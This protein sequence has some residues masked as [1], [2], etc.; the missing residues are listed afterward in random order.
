[1]DQIPLNE[2]QPDIPAMG[3][4]QDG[5]GKVLVDAAAFG[6]KYQSKREVYWFVSH[7]CG[8][9][10]PD[11]ANVSI[12]HLGDLAAGRRKRIKEETVRQK[13]VPHFEKLTIETMLEY[14]KEKP[15]LMEYLPI[16]ER[17]RV[18]LPR[19]YLANLIYTVV[20][21]PFKQWVDARVNDR[22]NLRRQQEHQIEMD[23]E[24][25]QAFQ[26]SKAVSGKSLWS[27]FI[28]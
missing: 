26:K 14:A 15:E 20:G 12:Y 8:V 22:H 4:Q 28:L 16:V 9:F 13:R 3:Q 11:Y 23:Y 6:A 24:I 19:E 18:K 1:M 5:N 7:E 2:N 10:V 27:L 21:Q 25:A 17:E